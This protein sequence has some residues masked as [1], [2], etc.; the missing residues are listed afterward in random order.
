MVSNAF[1]MLVNP[2]FPAQTVPEFI[3]YAKTNL[4]SINMASVGAGNTTRVSGE[5]FKS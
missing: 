1:A 4:G 5:L 2:A 3:A